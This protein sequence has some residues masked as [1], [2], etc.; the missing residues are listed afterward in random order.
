MGDEEVCSEYK[1]Y[2]EKPYL[3]SD[4]Q[5]FGLT[6]NG[7]T[8]EYIHAHEQVK[9]MMKKGKE[10]KIDDGVIKILDA[11][12]NKA[13]LNAIVE[14]S[15]NGANKGNVEIKVYNPSLNKKKGATIELRKMSSFDYIH[16]EN[17]RNILTALL[18]GFIAGDD[19]EQVLLSTRKDSNQKLVGKITSKPKLFT[20]DVCNWQT[21]FGSALK[22]HK[23]RIHNLSVN[24]ECDL[25]EFKGN[26][27][28]DLKEHNSSEHNLNKKRLKETFKCKFINCNSTFDS[29]VTLKKHT[30]DQHS[31]LDGIQ[32]FPTKSESLSSSPPRKKPDLEESFVND[33]EMID[34]AIEAN[35]MINNMLETR[36]KQLEKI[37]VDMQNEKKKDD[38]YIEKLVKE[39]KQLKYKPNI[40]TIPDSSA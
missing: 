37:V 5:P 14:A 21:K 4:R 12:T 19:V 10:Y 11:T 20:C 23:T 16:V 9:N 7:K 38:I 27:Q 24:H 17:L 40:S 39:I 33:I 26:S 13:M 22:A 6:I 28:S 25:C 3:N 8:K 18:D 36:V 2:K 30:N 32:S 29:D 35:D 31:S 15:F 1:V 34:I